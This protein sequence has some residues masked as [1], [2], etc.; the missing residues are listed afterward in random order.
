MRKRFHA[1][2]PTSALELSEKTVRRGQD[3]IPFVLTDD[4]LAPFV[5]R[6]SL[7]SV[8]AALRCQR[9]NGIPSTHRCCI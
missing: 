3:L 8:K 1:A 4:S 5:V 2:S 6:G 9:T 7:D